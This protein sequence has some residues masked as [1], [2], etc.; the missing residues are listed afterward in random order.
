M[1]RTGVSAKA[2][3][4]P[5]VFLLRPGQT[6]TALWE[7]PCQVLLMGAVLVEQGDWALHSP[8]LGLIAKMLWPG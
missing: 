1:G 4:G 6:Y 8:P 2:V 5:P 3:E 7:G